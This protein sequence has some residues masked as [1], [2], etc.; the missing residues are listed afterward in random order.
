MSSENIFYQLYWIY[1]LRYKQRIHIQ[2]VNNYI[3]ILY[4]LNSVNESTYV[5][6]KRFIS[7]TTSCPNVDK[8]WFLAI[9]DPVSAVVESALRIL[10]SLLA[11]DTSFFRL[12]IYII[13]V[14]NHLLG[15]RYSNICLCKSSL[16]PFRS[17]GVFCDPKGNAWGICL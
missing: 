16:T 13:K 10:M 17:A 15:P 11:N 14:Q 1:L 6:P 3:Q 12:H 7:A 9:S 8:P 5:S 2:E 4:H